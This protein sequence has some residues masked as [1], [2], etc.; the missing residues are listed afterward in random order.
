MKPNTNNPSWSDL[1]SPAILLA[2]WFGC[3][4][5]PKAPGTWGSLFALPFA[6]AIHSAFGGAGLALAAA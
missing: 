2:T 5:L 3:G 4:F 1:K 6:W